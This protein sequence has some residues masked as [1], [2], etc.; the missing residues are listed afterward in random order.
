MAH[1][2]RTEP[3]LIERARA[4][5]RRA[6]DDLWHAHRR[7]VAAIILAHRPRSVEVDD[8][9]QEVAVKFIAKLDTLRDP[10]A[11][12]PWLRQIVINVCRG[13]ARSERP[14]LRLADA[15][16]GDWNRSAIGQAATPAADGPA[17]DEI[18]ARDD[19]ARRL[20]HQALSLPPEYREPLLLRCVRSL[21]Y[22]QIS[23]I[24]D[25]PVTTIETR[26]ARARRM[27]REEVGEH[28]FTEGCT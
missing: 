14:T 20:M 16:R 26:L 21:S 13:A 27:L 19:V 18:A 9:M 1:Q 17:G 11:F 5:H 8:L 4:G 12:R 22:K 6:Q 3:G 23:D 25:L 10:R 2:Q 7:W 24:L 28:I 15:E